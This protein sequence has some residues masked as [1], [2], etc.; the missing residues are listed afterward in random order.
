MNAACEI[1]MKEMLKQVDVERN[2]QYIHSTFCHANNHDKFI[3]IMNN[4]K[5]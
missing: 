2:R 5:V 3:K 4:F 1:D